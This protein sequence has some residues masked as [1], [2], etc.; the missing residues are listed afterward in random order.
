M[1][2]ATTETMNKPRTET[3]RK[4]SEV[5]LSLDTFSNCV[6]PATTETIHKR[7]KD[8]NHFEKIKY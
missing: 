8:E 5:E 7:N 3:I 6:F 1:L 2:P 4:R